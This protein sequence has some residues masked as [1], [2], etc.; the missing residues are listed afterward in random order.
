VHYSLAV[1]P[2]VLL[3]LWDLLGRL[4]LAGLPLLLP[5]LLLLLLLL[6]LLLVLLLL[7]LLVLLLRAQAQLLQAGPCLVAASQQGLGSTPAVEFS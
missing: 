3:L 7:V 2:A 1:P 6:V 4:L 5:P